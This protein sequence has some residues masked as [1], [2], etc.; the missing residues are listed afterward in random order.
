MRRMILIFAALLAFSLPAFS[1]TAVGAWNVTF[2]LESGD[3]QQLRFVAF[4]DHTGVFR[5]PTPSATAAPSAFPAVWARPNPTVLNFSGEV[6]M[7]IPNCCTPS[8]TL[9]FKSGRTTAARMTGFVVFVADGQ[10]PALAVH[11]GTFTAVPA[12]VTP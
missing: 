7:E 3:A 8:G 9:V 6:R 11:Y 4:S 12:V 1:Q 5:F 10:P 2:S